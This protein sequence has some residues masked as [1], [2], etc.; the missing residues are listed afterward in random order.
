[1]NP[2]LNGYIPEE[3][4]EQTKQESRDIENNLE[5]SKN[6][7]TQKNPQE[8]IKELF[9][10]DNQIKEKKSQKYTLEQELQELD[11][12]AFIT[13]EPL[14][15]GGLTQEECSILDIKNPEE[16]DFRQALTEKGYKFYKQYERESW[17]GF[18]REYI[19]TTGYESE[20]AESDNKTLQSLETKNLSDEIENKSIKRINKEIPENSLKDNLD[21]ETSETKLRE[22]RAK[23]I[24][25]LLNDTFLHDEDLPANWNIDGTEEDVKKLENIILNSKHNTSENKERN[26]KIL[27]DRYGIA[28]GK[29]KTF[30]KIA[31]NFSLSTANIR[32]ITLKT[33]Q[34][35]LRSH[36]RETRITDRLGYYKE[37]ISNKTDELENIDPQ[38][39][40][41]LTKQSDYNPIEIG[42]KILEKLGYTVHTPSFAYNS[43]EIKVSDKDKNV[44]HH[45]YIGQ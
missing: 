3:T 35:L 8:I 39:L 43:L 19:K 18:F 15:N 7:E 14:P 1:M 24:T 12:H 2:E 44:V 27:F 29:P 9:E 13:I 10:L 21:Y 30:K 36:L 16:E 4:L 31:K 42:K 6:I 37:I 33:Q 22:K 40:E 34:F 32:K 45:E 17:Y 5:T 23:N 41:K 20:K 11:K 38:I 28:D 26:V 25:N